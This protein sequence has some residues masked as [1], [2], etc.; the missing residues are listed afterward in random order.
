M[1]EILRALLGEAGQAL[2]HVLLGAMPA[3]KQAEIGN[4]FNPMIAS[5]SSGFAEFLIGFSL[6]FMLLNGVFTN[7][8]LLS[9]SLFSLAV[10]A[11]LFAITFEGAYRT[12]SIILGKKQ[13]AGS[14]FYTVLEVLSAWFSMFFLWVNKLGGMIPKTK[15]ITPEEKKQKDIADNFKKFIEY[16]MSQPGL[17]WERQ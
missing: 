16:G 3:D 6:L 2:D 8:F 9:S 10:K 15:K 12:F 17:T 13:S 5:I 4:G 14:V 11:L 1:R 7:Y